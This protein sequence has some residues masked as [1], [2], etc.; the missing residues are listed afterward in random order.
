M[1]KIDVFEVA[2]RKGDMPFSPYL[3]IYL[4]EHFS[5][6][7]G[8]KLLSPKL[9]TDKEIDEAVDSLIMQLEKARKKAKSKLKKVKERHR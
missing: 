7:E 1:A 2:P 8:Y 5:G 6:S 9:M 4:S 3:N